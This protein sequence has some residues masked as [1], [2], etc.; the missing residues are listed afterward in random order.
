MLSVVLWT[1]ATIGVYLV[2]QRLARACGDTPLL[3]PVVTSTLALIAALALTHTPYARYARATSGLSFLLI[4]ATIALAVPLFRELRAIARDAAAI[5]SALVCGSAAIV[6]SAVWLARAFGCSDAIVRSFASKA[7]TTPVA[8]AVSAQIGGIP[9]LA[10]VFAVLSGVVGALVARAVLSR[11]PHRIAGVAIGT[12]SHGVGTARLFALDRS[13]SAFSGLA[14]GLNA[15]LTAIVLPLVA[16][17]LLPLALIALFATSSARAAQ[18]PIVYVPLDDRP[19]T[20]QLPELLGEIAGRRVVEP[21]RALLGHYLRFGDPDAIVAWLYGRAP[22]SDAYVL[23]SDMLL[24]GGLVASRVPATPYA[25]AVLRLRALDRLRARA[26]RAWIGVFGTIMRLAPTGVPPIGDGASFFA[27]YPAW[28]YLQAYANLHDPPLPSERADAARLRA[29]IGEPLLR[30]YLDARTRDYGLDRLLIERVRAGSFDEVV[31]GQDDAKPYGLH[32]PEYRALAAYAD[33]L[34]LGDRVAI[35]PGADELGMAY[36]ARALAR[37]ARWRPRVAIRYSTPDGAAY[38]D[39]LEFASIGDTIARLIARC[40]GVRDD[41]HPDL[42]LFVRVPHT[43]AVLDRAFVQAMRSSIAADVPVAL[44][45]LSFEGSY[46]DQGAFAQR[47][48][49]DGVASRLDAYASWNTD[50]NTVGTALAEAIAAGSGRRVGRYDALAHATFTFMRFADDVDFHV[51]VRPALNAW[52]DARGVTDHTLLVAPIADETDAR[53]RALLWYAAQ[54]TLAQLYPNLH[55]AA[56]RITLP[57]QRTFE[58]RIEARL[59][60]TLSP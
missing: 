29:L 58:T 9:A 24:Y 33:A 12:A 37:G 26:P 11:A 51:A 8:M 19:V 46:E 48:L 40:G 39:P 2:A 27:A 21:P 5:V 57:W 54:R 7:V 14:M 47:L 4:P 36:V 15:V 13:A 20:Q 23:S 55:V 53:N 31:L 42:T 6:L 22:A 59:A 10:G 52:L 41:L 3:H 30:A 56:L 60:P 50:A 35:E 43:G 28:T 1:S 38:Q 17:W 34:G 18:P 32:V 25:T 16:R 44:A 49:D 45:D